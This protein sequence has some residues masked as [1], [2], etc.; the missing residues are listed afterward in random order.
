VERFRISHLVLLTGLMAPIQSPDRN[1]SCTSVSAEPTSAISSLSAR[2]PIWGYFHPAWMPGGMDRFGTAALAR[3]SRDPS[4]RIEGSFQ[5]PDELRSRV[6]FWAAVY[7]RFDSRTKIIHD[8][9][10]PSL[11]YGYIDFAPLYEKQSPMGAAIQS[12][13]VEQAVLSRCEHAQRT[14]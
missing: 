3:L 1:F 2:L 6:L 12:E 9:N 4:S 11:I 10:D 8:R 5:I 13:R 14:P 7:S